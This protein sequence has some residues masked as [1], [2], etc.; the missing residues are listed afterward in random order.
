K[1]AQIGVL[2]AINAKVALEGGFTALGEFLEDSTV[3]TEISDFI[4]GPIIANMVLSAQLGINRLKMV[5]VPIIGPPIS[6]DHTIYVNASAANTFET[7]FAPDPA[8]EP[9]T[10]Q[11][12]SLKLDLSK[13]SPLLDIFG[14]SLV[15]ANGD[16]PN[17]WLTPPGD[18]GPIAATIVGTPT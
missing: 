6:Q 17:V 15:N 10:P 7:S 13:Q 4:A 1:A 3:G 14:Q 5:A 8:L 2:D 16:S 11:I 12:T 18:T 9:Q